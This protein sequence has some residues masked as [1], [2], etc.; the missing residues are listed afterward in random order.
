MGEWR[1]GRGIPFQRGESL[2]A[3]DARRL[4]MNS[5]EEPGKIAVL[6]LYAST[7][8]LGGV[9]VFTDQLQAALDHVEVFAEPPEAGGGSPWNLERV[10]MAQAYTAHR[11]AQRFRERHREDPFALVISN[12]LSG[13]PLSLQSVD[14]P[15]VQVYHFTLAGFARQALDHR[16]DRLTTRTVSAFFDGWAGR[17]KHVITVNPHILREVQRFY[18]LDGQVIRNAVDTDLFQ[19]VDPRHARERLGI[20]PDVPLGLCVGRAEYA[21]GFDILIDVAE[22]L[23]EVQF[24]F[25]GPAPQAVPNLQVFDRV[26]HAEMPLLYSAAD[27]FLLPSRYEGLNLAILEALAC[28]LPLVVSRAAYQLPEDPAPLGYVAEGLDPQEYVQGIREV[29]DAGASYHGRETVLASYSFDA[30]RANWRRL[31]GGL[32]GG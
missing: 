27:F 2:L 5:V 4:T 7:D 32:V 10:G 1:D 18:G 24:A 20:D 11:V 25:V 28:D 22:S 3:R 29:L 13:W 16:G 23:P 17:G 8:L 15:M 19:K 12:G 14:I 31:V 21:K 6:T 30:F 9:E 26:P